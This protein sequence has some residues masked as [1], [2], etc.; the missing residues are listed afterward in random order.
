MAHPPPACKPDTPPH[1]HRAPPHS[2][3]KRSSCSP[4]QPRRALGSASHAAVPIAAQPANEP[5]YSATAQAVNPLGKAPASPVPHAHRPRA[6]SFPP[7]AR[8]KHPSPVHHSLPAESSA[9]AGRSARLIRPQNANCYP[10]R[11]TTKPLDSHRPMR[12][13]EIAPETPREATRWHRRI[14]STTLSLFLQTF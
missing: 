14:R 12:Q 4:R 13:P 2:S 11:A 5:P 7:A 9:I 10:N 6:P 3:G 1:Q 8:S